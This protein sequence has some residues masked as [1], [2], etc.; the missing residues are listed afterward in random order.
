[1]IS[2]AEYVFRLGLGEV[3]TAAAV[4]YMLFSIFSEFCQGKKIKAILIYAAFETAYVVLLTITEES[5]MGDGIIARIIMMVADFFVMPCYL[6]GDWRW[7]RYI[8]LTLLGELIASSLGTLLLEPVFRL[9]GGMNG[10]YMQSITDT[11]YKDPKGFP[12]LL[13][14]YALNFLAYFL[15]SKILRKILRS[16]RRE[17]ILQ[18]I[19]Q[20]IFC[21]LFFIGSFGFVIAG[22][23]IVVPTV[24]TVLTTC[25]LGVI[26]IIR[27]MIKE[28]N[29][30]MRK[31]IL[32]EAQQK[33]QY[34]RY[35]Q[36]KQKQNEVRKIRHDLA[37]HMMTVRMLLDRGELEQAREYAEATETVRQ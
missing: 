20:A 23:S 36:L 14:Y 12:W 6:M 4:L 29:Y 31:E 9:A 8:G 21:S 30:L 26:F 35:V 2:Y 34:E 22:E 33:L 27:G 11:I 1:M 13:I 7:Y 19:S 25:T 3:F 18:N 5:L 17:R 16:A 15:L 37:D 10:R 32:I 28:R 24:I